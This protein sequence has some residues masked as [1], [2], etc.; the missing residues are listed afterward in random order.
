MDRSLIQTL[1]FIAGFLTTFA[2]T[3]Q[4]IHTWKTGGKDLSWSMLTLFGSGV[5][6]WLLYG[7]LLDMMPVIVA[8][9]LTILQIAAIAAIKWTRSQ[10]PAP[11]GRAA[12]D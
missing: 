5:C 12:F 9:G 10:A 4:V 3:P 7:I 6:L 1:G 2:F 8:N 11:D